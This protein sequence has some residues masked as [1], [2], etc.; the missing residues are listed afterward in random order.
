MLMKKDL[1]KLSREELGQLFPIIISEPNPDW[2]A[3]FL[4]EKERI[5]ELLGEK[6]AIRIEHVGST[7]VSNLPAKPTIDIAVEI[8]AGEDVETRIT[9][10][11][12]A[13][14]Y[15]FMHEKNDHLMFVKGYT[16]DGVKP[17]SYHI[18]MGSIDKDI[19]WDML[20][21][22]NLLRANASVADEYSKL[23][24]ELALLH[25]NDRE[26]YTDAKTTFITKALQDSQQK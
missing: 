1:H 21:F 6:I 4:Q 15:N 22:R 8:P 16:P 23:K 14:G 12:T 17:T 20:I 18:H 25:K 19:V 2:P 7:A 5:I 9:S 3:L 24:R 26:A 10:I 11:M 13:N